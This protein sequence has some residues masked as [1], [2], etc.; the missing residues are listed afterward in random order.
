MLV[1]TPLEILEDLVKLRLSK[2]AKALFA[3]RRKNIEAHSAELKLP[4]S[5]LAYLTAASTVV[6]R[7]YGRC[8]SARTP[9]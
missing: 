9:H 6:S 2:V 1:T 7:R 5:D 8:G 4:G 3:L